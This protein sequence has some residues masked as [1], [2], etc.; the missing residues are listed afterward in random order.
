MSKHT[1]GPWRFDGHGVN[2]ADGQ[3][4]ATLRESLKH[5]PEGEAT[6]AAL[7][8]APELLEALRTIARSSTGQVD[9]SDDDIEAAFAGIHALALRA[10]AKAEG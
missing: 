1:P 9:Q 6:G 7:A 4:I 3:R 5:S 8:A 2:A 10:I